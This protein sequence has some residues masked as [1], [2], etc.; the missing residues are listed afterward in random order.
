MRAGEQRPRTAM[1]HRTSRPRF[2]I[3][4]SK[5]AE[6]PDEAAPYPQS[7]IMTANRRSQSNPIIKHRNTNPCPFQPLSL[8]LSPS[9]SVYPPLG[10]IPLPCSLSLF[11]PLPL[12]L[13]LSSLSL[14]I[15]QSLISSCPSLSIARSLSIDH[16][17]RISH[18]CP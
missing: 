16:T 2:R 18:C 6:G 7:F 3:R 17:I 10:Q 14:S 12:S 9:L 1:S 13:A 11:L 4:H 5:R 8:S 15:T